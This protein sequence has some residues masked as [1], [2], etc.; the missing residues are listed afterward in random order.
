MDIVG[1]NMQILHHVRVIAV[2]MINNSYMDIAGLNMQ[3]LHHVRVIAVNV[4]NHTYMDIAGLNMQ[5]LHHV[6]VIKVN[7]INLTYMAI[8]GLNKRLFRLPVCYSLSPLRSHHQICSHHEPPYSLHL[9]IPFF[10]YR[11]PPRLLLH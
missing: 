9:P 5:I 4:I 11:E 1:L 7:V 3:I 8:A 10:L 2:N 6:R